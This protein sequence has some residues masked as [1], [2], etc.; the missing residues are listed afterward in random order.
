M[1]LRYITEQ[2]LINEIPEALQGALTDDTPNGATKVS[3][4]IVQQGESAEETVES[5]LGMLYTI[6]LQANDNTV[7]NSLKKAIFVLTKYYLYMRRDQVDAQMQAQYDTVMRWLKDI[8]SG[9][10]GL[11]LLR[12]DGTVQTQGGQTITVSMVTN[13]EFSRFV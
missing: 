4:I 9:R 2:E 8:A 10:A 13:S 5:Y 11:N 12:A 3:S 6:P 1:P 7:P